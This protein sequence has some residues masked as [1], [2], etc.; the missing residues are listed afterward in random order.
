MIKLYKNPVPDKDL[1]GL[2][3]VYPNYIKIVIDIEKGIMCAGGEYHIDCEEVLIN[4]GSKQEDLWGGGLNTLTKQIDFQALSN[5]KPSLGKL[6]YEIA[7]QG[8]RQKFSDY[9]KYFFNL[10]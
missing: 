7:D 3:E 6:T 2:C 1:K 4:N 10:P 5:Y 8:I 9:V